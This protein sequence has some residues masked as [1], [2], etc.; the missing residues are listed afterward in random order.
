VAVQVAKFHR[1]SLAEAAAA[2]Q[3]DTERML[4]L[5]HCLLQAE[6]LTPLRWALV[7]QRLATRLQ[8]ETTH[9]SPESFPLEAAV[10]HLH[11]RE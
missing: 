7:E 9:H 10:E 11:F 5:R 6:R 2:A 8:A 1:F 4:A 3:A